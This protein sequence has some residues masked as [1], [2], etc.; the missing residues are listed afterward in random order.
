MRCVVVLLFVLPAIV[1]HAE[2]RPSDVKHV[3]VYYEPGRFGGWPANQGIWNWG[4]EILVGFSVGWYQDLGPDRHHINREKAEMH[5]LARSKDG[6]ETWTPFDP[7]KNGDLIPEPGFLHGKPRT[8][9]D[10]P[11]AKDCPGGIDFTHPD[12]AMTVR[13][14]S[15]HDGE[16]R[17]WYSYDRGGSWQ[18]PFTLPDFGT[19]G[20]AARTDY[21]VNSQLDCLLFMTVAKPDRKEGRPVCVRTRDGGKTWTLEGWIGAEPAGF[22]I[23]PATVRTS[24]SGLLSVLRCREDS[25][26]WLAAYASDDNGKTWSFVNNPVSDLGEGN[27]GAL[28]KLRDGRLCL[29]YGYRAKPF[30]IR[31]RLSDDNG[32]T[33]GDD[34]VLRD[35]GADRDVGYPRMVQRPDGKVVVVYYISDPK[36]G[37]ERYIGAT[38]FDP[39]SV[40]DKH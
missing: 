3:K 19:P 12:F 7:G 18:G 9:V 39:D 16:A 25:R 26:R 34:I 24:E 32:Q 35:D 14:T 33:W 5:W 11:F 31:V 10:I 15:I 38:I 29:S 22:A 37:P 6:G 21:V 28:I 40:S 36:T 2:H 23:M 4:N 1:A 30:S 13:T 20:T 8:D 27:P 17:L